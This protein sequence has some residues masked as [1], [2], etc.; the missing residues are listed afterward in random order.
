M[1]AIQAFRGHLG[2]VV[3]DGPDFRRPT[4]EAVGPGDVGLLPVG[5]GPHG[6]GVL[7]AEHQRQHY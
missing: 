5:D 2:E 4:G 1:D 3:V 6:G 7:G